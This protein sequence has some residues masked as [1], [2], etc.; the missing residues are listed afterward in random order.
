MDC[1]LGNDAVA[2]TIVLD[3]EE[4]EGSR[5][6]SRSFFNLELCMRSQV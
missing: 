1:A 3:D 6:K 2:P 4:I 5:K